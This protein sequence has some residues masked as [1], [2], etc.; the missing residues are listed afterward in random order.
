[1]T[2]S[3]EQFDARNRKILLNMLGQDDASRKRI[4]SKA[5]ETLRTG[6]IDYI[7]NGG[8]LPRTFSASIGFGEIVIRIDL[9]EEAATGT[10]ESHYPEDAA[11]RAGGAKE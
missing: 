8:E 1:M 6:A 9:D 2:E 10:Y 4:M 3:R 11:L 5:L 7:E